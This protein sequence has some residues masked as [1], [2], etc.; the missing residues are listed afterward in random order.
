MVVALMSIHILPVFVHLFIYRDR[1]MYRSD[2]RIN[3]R[4][5]LAPLTHCAS[6]ASVRCGAIERY[7]HR[8]TDCRTREDAAVDP[9]RPKAAEKPSMPGY[10]MLDQKDKPKSGS[11]GLR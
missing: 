2:A 3:V 8:G 7:A 10:R 6:A 4:A 1:V 9:E 5:F 11:W